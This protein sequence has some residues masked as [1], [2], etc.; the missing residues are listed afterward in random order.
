MLTPLAGGRRTRFHFRSRWVTTPWW[1]S[2][3]GWLGIVPA[4]FVM[5]RDHLRNVKKRAEHLALAA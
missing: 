2:L 3:G 1:F 5:S 4:D